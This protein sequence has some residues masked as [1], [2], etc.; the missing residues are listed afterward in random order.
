MSQYVGPF[1]RG[2]EAFWRAVTRYTLLYLAVLI[3]ILYQTASDA[4]GL[5]KYLYPDLGVPVQVGMHTY[6][7]NCDFEWKNIYDNLDHYYLMH[8]IGW[9]VVTLMIRDPIILHFWSLLDEVLGNKVHK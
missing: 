4:R 2:F 5:F 3:F 6:D 1:T 8:L 9:F 7:D